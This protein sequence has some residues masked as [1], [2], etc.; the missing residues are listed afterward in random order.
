MIEA[1]LSHEA[2]LA[3]LGI[4]LPDPIEPIGTYVAAV[5]S[6]D[7]LFVSGHGPRGDDRSFL[8]GKVGRDVS[9]DEARRRA[10]LVGLRLLG[11]VRRTLGSLDRVRRVVKVFGMVNASE[12]FADH[13]QVIDGC[14]NLFVE[15]F[16]DAG[17]HARSAVGMGSLPKALTVEIEAVFETHSPLHEGK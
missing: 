6:G 8:T 3:E 11:S 9:I 13:P 15:V 14:S 17:R 10:R 5:L 16:G 2:R 1:N 12:D 7:L 4:V